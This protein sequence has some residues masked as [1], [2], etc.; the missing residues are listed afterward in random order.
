MAVTVV[1]LVAL[2]ELQVA[3]A[4][5]EEEVAVVAL[6]VV[7]AGAEDI[8]THSKAQQTST[9]LLVAPLHQTHLVFDKTW[10]DFQNI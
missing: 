10:L 1:A 5:E 2:Q 4:A 6:V 8:D 9:A 3:G 7:E